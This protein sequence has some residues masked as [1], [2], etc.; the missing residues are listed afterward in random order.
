MAEFTFEDLKGILVER[1]G[2]A[3]A[4]IPDDL[5][6]SF[7]ELGLDSLAVVEL[8]LA[9][10]QAYGLTISDEDAGQITTLASAIDYVNRE[11]TGEEVT[12]ASAN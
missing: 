5:D 3:D 6:A 12:S 1:I 9:V 2:V 10:E 4:D 8:Q 7:E 11:L